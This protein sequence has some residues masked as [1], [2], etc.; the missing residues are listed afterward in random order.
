MAQ[1]AARVVRRGRTERRS[2]R[3]TFLQPIPAVGH[4]VCNTFGWVSREIKSWG[5]RPSTSA[6][7]LGRTGVISPC[8][9]VPSNSGCP[10]TGR[11]RAAPHATAPAV[12]GASNSDR[13][14][15]RRWP[16]GVHHRCPGDGRMDTLVQMLRRYLVGILDGRMTRPPRRWRRGRHLPTRAGPRC[17]GRSSP[18]RWARCSSGLADRSS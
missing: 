14:G 13:A 15:D 6:S 3:P 17:R 7:M 4:R 2:P 8:A 5:G 16:E 10:T 18:R 12:A 11:H 9:P 1:I